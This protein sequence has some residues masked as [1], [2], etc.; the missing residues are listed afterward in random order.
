MAKKEIKEVLK[1]IAQDEKGATA[2]EYSII[3]S[4]IAGVIILIVTQIGSKVSNMFVIN[5]W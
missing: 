5:G 2:I 3:A 4:L 1:S